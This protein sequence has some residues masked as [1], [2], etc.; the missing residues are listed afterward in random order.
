MTLSPSPFYSPVPSLFAES[1]I[2]L[3]P[4]PTSKLEL[5]RNPPLVARKQS[6]SRADMLSR[7]ETENFA[8]SRLRSLKQDMRRA[9]WT[10][11]ISPL[12]EELAQGHKNSSDLL[13][14]KFPVF[15]HKHALCVRVIMMLTFTEHHLLDI[16][17]SPLYKLFHRLV[18]G[19]NGV[20]V[21]MSQT[22]NLGLRGI[23]FPR[24]TSLQVREPEAAAPAF[25]LQS[26]KSRPLCVPA[27]C[28]LP[29]LPSTSLQIGSLQ[30]DGCVWW[31]I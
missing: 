11:T 9:S 31:G 21:S 6:H 28:P 14:E 16:V 26:W 8:F 23:I 30:S 25:R 3:L 2:I 18:I 5:P 13:D 12:W 24:S 29:D 19:I 7:L 27:G 10:N 15:P 22:G 1:F 4:L 17:L 20:S